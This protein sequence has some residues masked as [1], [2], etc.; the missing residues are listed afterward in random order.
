MF[1]TLLPEIDLAEAQTGDLV[2]YHGE[3]REQGTCKQLVQ[4]VH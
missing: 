4:S 3:Y 2:F 1:D